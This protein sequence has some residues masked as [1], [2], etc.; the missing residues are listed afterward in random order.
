[1]VVR[2]IEPNA[3]VR[4]RRAASS[5]AQPVLA[6]V[7]KVSAVRDAALGD[8]GHYGPSASS[9]WPRLC[10]ITAEKCGILKPTM[11]KEST[12]RRFTRPARSISR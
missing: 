10:V 5:A 2:A 8:W 1:M 4:E 6:H 7:S 12:E 11:A 9:I 3:V